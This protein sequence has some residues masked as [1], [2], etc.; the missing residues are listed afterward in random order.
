MSGLTIAA[1]PAFSCIFS[2][3][4]ILPAASSSHLVSPPPKASRHFRLFGTQHPVSL[5]PLV[6]TSSSSSSSQQLPFN[7]QCAV[8]ITKQPPRLLSPGLQDILPTL[9]SLYRP[10]FNITLSTPRTLCKTSLASSRDKP[11]G[12]AGQFLNLYLNS[13]HPSPFFYSSGSLVSGLSHSTLEVVD[14]WFEWIFFW[15][16]HL[17]HFV[18]WQEMQRGYVRPPCLL[19]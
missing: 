1:V 7:A 15:Q 4:A 6:S 3:G 8:A 5:R 18:S 11:P 14:G 19:G 10:S 12:C 16:R 9:S 17:G 13:K 2:R